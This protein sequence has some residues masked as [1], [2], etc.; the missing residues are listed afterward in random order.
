MLKFSNNL[1]NTKS[2]SALLIRA[3]REITAYYEIHRTR[4]NP[5]IFALKGKNA[6]G[7]DFWTPFQDKWP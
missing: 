3:D 7:Y 5:A 2:N 1:Y 6:L 4:N